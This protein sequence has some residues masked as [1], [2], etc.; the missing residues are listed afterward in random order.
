M[1]HSPMAQ[2]AI[3]QY[4]SMSLLL[5]HCHW[6]KA[7]MA[8][9]PMTQCTPRN[10]SAQCL[11]SRH[12]TST[13][14]GHYAKHH[15]S[16]TPSFR[17][18]I[19]PMQKVGRVHLTR[20]ADTS[21]PCGSPC[22]PSVCFASLPRGGFVPFAALRYEIH[23]QTKEGNITARYP[24]VRKKCLIGSI[25]CF[26]LV[27]A[28]SLSDSYPA[29]GFLPLTPRSCLAKEGSIPGDWF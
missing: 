18:A 10:P 25:L 26:S 1:A 17:N 24:C 15:R 28:W 11:E 23:A 4:G 21:T 14:V 22:H 20:D 29:G 2:A 6:A 16:E 3:A 9:C 5:G 19:V 7:N 8:Q 27:F 13:S 12:S